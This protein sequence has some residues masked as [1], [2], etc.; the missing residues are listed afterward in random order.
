MTFAPR[1]IGQGVSGGDTLAFTLATPGA[2][3]QLT[4]QI[5]TFSTTFSEGDTL[6]LKFQRL[7]SD[8][9]DTRAADLHIYSATVSYKADGPVE[10]SKRFNA[11]TMS[12]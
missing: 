7:G 3:T 10:A 4:E 11:P 5:V 12:V 8:G 9:L 2:A 6:F 1:A